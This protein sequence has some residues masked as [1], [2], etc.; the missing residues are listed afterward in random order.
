MSSLFAKKKG[1]GRP[2]KTEIKVEALCGKPPTD[3]GAVEIAKIIRLMIPESTS[4]KLKRSKVDCP[5]IE[6][7]I[8]DAVRR[9][10]KLSQALHELA[11][12]VEKGDAPR[13]GYFALEA[14][15][16]QETAF[17]DGTRALAEKG[18][19]AAQADRRRSVKQKIR[20]S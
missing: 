11:D 1:R 4:Q 17:R 5:G 16:G 2:K 3:L 7:R 19:R 10:K 6:E 12:A 18:L 13:A 15:C 9:N 20:R 14:L 8:S